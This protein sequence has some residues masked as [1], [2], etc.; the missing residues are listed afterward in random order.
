MKR[1]SILFL[2]FMIGGASVVAQTVNP[3]RVKFR[4]LGL[5]STYQQIFNKLGKPKSDKTNDEECIGAHERTI[6]YDGLLIYLMDG[7]SKDGKT[8]EVK[9]FEVTDGKWLVAGLKV[10]DTES[11]V[12]KLFGRRYTVD[13]DSDTGEKRWVYNMSDRFGPGATI[14]SFKNGKVVNISSGYQVC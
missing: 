5:D 8:F 4:G 13:H 10:G 7:D 6:E 14:V 9:S 2:V 11:T 12:R 1:V 3:A